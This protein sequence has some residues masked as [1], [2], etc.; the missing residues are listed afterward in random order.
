MEARRN[1]DALLW[2]DESGF[3]FGDRKSDLQ[4]DE[5]LEDLETEKKI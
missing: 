3:T 4:T 2:S 5:K 1:H